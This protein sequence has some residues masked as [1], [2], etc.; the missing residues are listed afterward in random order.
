VTKEE[1]L[2]AASREED[3]NVAIVKDRGGWVGSLEY[4]SR[5]RLSCKRLHV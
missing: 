2:L 3:A 4:M 5:L 1:R